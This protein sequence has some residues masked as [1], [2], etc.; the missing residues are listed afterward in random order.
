[1]IIYGNGCSHSKHTDT[2]QNG[3]SGFYLSEHFK[4]KNIS[5]WNIFQWIQPVTFDKK[6][7]SIYTEKDNF[8][9]NVSNDGK[10]N[11]AIYFE[12]VDNI[13]KLID[14]DCKPNLVTIQWS[15]PSRRMVMDTIMEN[16]N[17]LDTTNETNMDMFITNCNP[18][19]HSHLLP[20]LDPL[21]SIQTLF[22]I[23]S[24]QEF[25]KKHKINY[26]FHCYMELSLEIKNHF[27]FDKID[28][29]KFVTFSNEDYFYEGWLPRM[30]NK[31]NAIIDEQGHP[32]V[33]GK[34]Y[35]AHRILQKLNEI[36]DIKY[37]D[38]DKKFFN[39]I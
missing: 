4:L 7:Q 37:D 26:T 36:Y 10:S 5:T 28:T 6:L 34:Q 35:I 25:L 39:I 13:L 8:V 30:K 21:G 17:K 11:D 20:H 16:H 27:I 24:M 18:N 32:S 14:N 3:S 19:D 31:P 33:L 38:Y 9:L 15:G 23:Y 29:S 2:L 1:M 12:S 22:F